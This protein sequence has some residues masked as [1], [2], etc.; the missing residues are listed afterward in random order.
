VPDACVV[1]CAQANHSATVQSQFFIGLKPMAYL[2]LQ[3]CEMPSLKQI[4][5]VVNFLTDKCGLKQSDLST[6]ASNFP[7]VFG[8]SVESQLQVAYDVMAEEWKMKAPVLIAVLKR[9]PQAL[10]CNVDC[11]GTCIGQ[12]DRCWVRY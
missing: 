7:Q 6:L 9:K 1:S 2:C 12:C 4:E 10:G 11:E 5:G 3:D 8:C